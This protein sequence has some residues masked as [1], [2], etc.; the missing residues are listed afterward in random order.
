MESEA[1]RV[2]RL[3]KLRAVMLEH[4]RKA[5]RLKAI[6]SKAYHRSAGDEWEKG[7]DVLY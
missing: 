3:A 5:K 1:A 6:K 7:R 2:A 4:Q